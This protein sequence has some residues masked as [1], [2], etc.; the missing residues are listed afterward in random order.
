MRDIHLVLLFAGAALVAGCG[1]ENG[2]NSTG[3]QGGQGAGGGGAGQGAQGGQGGGGSSGCPV[4]VAP[5]PGTVIVASG[6]VSG[7]KVGTTWA[8]RGIPYAAPPTG[9][10]RW[11]AP[12]PA[13]CLEG[14]LAA[15]DFGPACKQLDANGDPTGSEDCL[16]IN[17]WSPADATAESPVPVLF[18]IHGGGNT[19]GSSSNAVGNVE[20]YDGQPL[21]ELGHVAVVTIN[22]RLGPFGWLSHPSF[23]PEG[24]PDHTGN[25]GALDQVFALGW[26]KENIAAFG[27]DPSRV[28][29]FGESAG[30]QNTALMLT[31]P[32]AKGLFS[33]ALIESG[34]FSAQT[35]AEAL[36]AAD[37]WAQKAGCDADPDPAGCM[38]KM[39]EDEVVALVP[40]PADVAGKQG[41]FQ[42]HVDGYLLEDLPFAVLAAGKHNHVPFVMGANENETGQT[43]PDMTEAEY[44]AAV[45]VLFGALAPQVLAEY[46]VADFATP[47][48]AYVAL[49]SDVKFICSVRRS[50]RAA[51]AAQDEPVFRYHFTHVL[52]NGG[53]MA[54]KSGAFHGLELFFVFGHLDVAGYV[55]SAEEKALSA[56]IG[57]Y[58][59]RFGGAG[60]PNGGGAVTWPVYDPVKDSY[61]RLDNM[62]TAEEGVRTDKC[63]FWDGLITP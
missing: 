10:R 4:D 19:Q 26:V 50:L 20:L 22:Y 59:S 24:A 58:W 42:P 47:R 31:T 29:V 1:P 15:T 48:D 62:I 25:Y 39:T 27:G 8:Y 17:V 12:E 7:Q 18:F 11:K 34:G 21:S 36:A 56:A 44:T 13:S 16:T 38:R 57:G 5:E 51:A 9:E 43:V 23:A 40:A 32:L 63:D 41:P 45:T 53:P 37:D 55:A 60:D 35:A 46:A 52:D 3:G 14:V 54:K 49:T 2:S 30:G 28:M 33:S 6:A 61:L